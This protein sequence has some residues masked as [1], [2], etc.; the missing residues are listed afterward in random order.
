MNAEVLW[1]ILDGHAK[2]LASCGREGRR[3]NLE[4]ANLE[5]ADLESADLGLANLRSANLRLADLKSA[6]LWLADLRLANLASTCLDPE[7]DPNMQVEEFSQED[8]YVVGYRTRATGHAVMYRDDRRYSADVFSVADTEC[9]PGLYLWPTLGHAYTWSK[10]ETIK[11]LTKAT[12]VHKAGSKW[13]CRWFQV[14]GT[15]KG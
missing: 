13:R 8:G 5:S 14:V 12:E 9:H 2:W 1:C 11:V 6:Y 10:A 15:V 3:A 4:S 7:A